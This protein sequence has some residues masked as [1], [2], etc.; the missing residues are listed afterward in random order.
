MNSI[1]S[2]QYKII[3]HFI[4]HLNNKRF[5]TLISNLN[6]CQNYCFITYKNGCQ[7]CAKPPIWRTRLPQPVKWFG[8]IMRRNEC[9]TALIE[10]QPEGK[11]PQ[12]RPRKR[13]LDIIEENLKTVG[14]ANNET[15]H[16]IMDLIDFK[17]MNELILQWCIFKCKLSQFRAVKMFRFPREVFF[18]YV[19]LKIYFFISNYYKILRFRKL[20]T[21]FMIFIKKIL[22]IST[23]LIYLQGRIKGG[24]SSRDGSP[25][26]NSSTET[27]TKRVGLNFCFIFVFYNAI[28]NL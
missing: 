8:H 24:G 27:C 19:Y 18:Y 3:N 20:F 11:R 4:K 28:D 6:T 21:I 1:N 22:I 26:A 17:T 12:S 16:K 23:L 14:H 15:M 25:G 10:W 13:L 2:S 7:P 9:E 5:S